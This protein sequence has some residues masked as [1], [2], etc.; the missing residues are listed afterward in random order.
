MANIELFR[1]P[2]GDEDANTLYINEE[3]LK[4]NTKKVTPRGQ[5]EIGDIVI[6]YSHGSTWVGRGSQNR[7]FETHTVVGVEGTGRKK[8]WY[9]IGDGQE[10]PFPV[11]SAYFKSHKQIKN[12][13][14]GREE[15]SYIVN[16]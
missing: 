2:V 11:D 3:W 14:L 7:N 10:T 9:L 16:S 12:A 4:K 15:G 1:Q 8:T 13:Y 5:P 6:A